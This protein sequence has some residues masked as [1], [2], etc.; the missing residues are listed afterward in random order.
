MQISPQL[1]VTGS[2]EAIGRDPLRSRGHSVAGGSARLAAPTTQWRDY[3]RSL[4]SGGGLR[5]WNPQFNVE[6][7]RAQLA[8]DYLDRGIGQLRALK[9]TLS[10]QMT[11]DVAQQR[12]VRQF[13]ELWRERSAQTAGSVGPGLA[14]DAATPARR[15]FEIRGMD[16]RS[17]QNGDS[18]S[19]SF[20]LAGAGGRPLAVALEAG[21]AEAEIVRRFDHALASAGI[22]ASGNGQGGLIFSVEE[23]G[24]PVVRDTLAVRGGGIRWPT[25]QFNRVQAEAAPDLVDP[26]TWSVDGME[27]ARTTLKHTIAA[28]DAFTVARREVDVAVAAVT[29]L[30]DVSQP[31]FDAT[32]ASD[33]A[34][35]FEALGRSPDYRA[36]SQFTAALAGIRRERVHALL[37]LR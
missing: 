31:R 18:E 13:A 25:G 37:E 29:D 36:L 28:L 33:F 30:A 9:A 7:G 5:T 12:R 23:S 8:A 14:F 35:S 10:Q 32:Q 22:R 17:L 24:W 19:L 2:I 1:P 3:R 4:Q 15:Q 20:S 6:V 34:Q 11:G 16:I 21:L 27:A 26:A